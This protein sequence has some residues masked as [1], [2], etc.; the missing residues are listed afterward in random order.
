M[1]QIDPERL[2]DMALRSAVAQ[3]CRLAF[4]H[5]MR[6]G[7]Q[8]ISSAFELLNRAA[9]HTQVVVSTQS[10]NLVDELEP[11]DLIVVD[12]EPSSGASVFRRPTQDEAREWLDDY[13]L[14]ELWQKNVLGGRP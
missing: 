1:D 8:S 11:T 5:D 4:L 6:G 2:Q 13:S 9:H 10:V 7:L 12:R 14:G 3:R